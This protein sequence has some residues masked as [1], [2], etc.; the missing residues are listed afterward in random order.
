L[1]QVKQIRKQATTRRQLQ[2][3]GKITD[4]NHRLAQHEFITDADGVLRTISYAIAC[5]Y[6]VHMHP[7]GIVNGKKI[8]VHRD[9]TG[10]D[11]I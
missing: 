3:V 7:A 5:R 11:W 8:L 4:C 10:R 6:R 2:V 1:K 9:S